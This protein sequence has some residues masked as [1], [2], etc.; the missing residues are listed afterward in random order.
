MN[1][2][3]REVA[4]CAGMDWCIRSSVLDADAVTHELE[5][6]PSRAWAKG[7]R[8]ISKRL[9]SETGK[10][11][12][13]WRVRPWGIWGL[14]TKGM[15]DSAGV[16]PHI[17]FLLNLLEPKDH[18][19]GRYLQNPEEYTIRFTIRWES[20]IGHGGFAVSSS[21]VARMARLC[22]YLQFT[23]VDFCDSVEMEG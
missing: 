22:H 8:Y 4:R 1:H 7:D 3:E 6:E 19:I 2:S 5:I 14:N 12:H 20:N 16:E 11:T 10:I 17:L 21:A 9:D 18:V 13:V 15:V 23:Y